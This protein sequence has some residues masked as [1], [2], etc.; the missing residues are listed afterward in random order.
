MND[1]MAQS[2]RALVPLELSGWK[3]AASWTGAIL[4]SLLFLV[5][6][7]WKITDAPAAA[8]RMTQALIPEFLSL[9]AAIGFGIVE[10]FAA[11]LILLPRYRRWGAVLASLL[12]AAFMVYFAVFY[13]TLRGEE[14]NCFPWVERVVGPAF[15]IGDAIMLALAIIAGVWARPVT[16]SIRSAVVI[17]AAV[18]V[19]ALVS[20]GVAATRHT[21]TRA[22][23]SITVDGKP[24]SLQHGRVLI[25][26][27]DPECLH[28]LHAAQRMATFDWMDTR[29]VAAPVAQPAFA[30]SFLN[31]AGLKV[32][33]TSDGAKLRETFPFVDVPAAAAIDEGR[34]AAML[35]QW[36]GDAAERELRKLGFIR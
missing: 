3:T 22:P 27:F 18:T 28:C 2:E 12:L 17:V 34:Q 26:F 8:V 6:G 16:G 32:P 25:Y 30:Q 20:Y 23:A 13:N 31:D 19:F 7:L 36:D 14:C 15:F 1:S 11:V 35:L 33:V 4:T 5:S 9:P 21:G 24:Y 29:V 10:T